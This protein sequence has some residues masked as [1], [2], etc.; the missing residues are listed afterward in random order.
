MSAI[1]ITSLSNSSSGIFAHTGRRRSAIL[2]RVAS[3]FVSV[4]YGCM[5]PSLV[6]FVQRLRGLRMPFQG[7]DTREIRKRSG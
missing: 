6:E 7:A 3:S 2:R 5:S 1:R 4:G